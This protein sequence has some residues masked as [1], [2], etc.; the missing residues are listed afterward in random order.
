[1]SKILLTAFK[2]KY[3]SS[4]VLVDKITYDNIEKLFLTNSMNKLVDELYNQNLESFDLI[5]MFGINK[6]LKNCLQLEANALREANLITT[7][8]NIEDIQ[9]FFN[10][11]GIE[12]KINT[13]PSAYL[14]NN[15][16]YH[17][18]LKNPKGVFIHIPGL[19]KIDDLDNLIKIIKEFINYF[20]NNLR[21]N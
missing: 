7:T 20:V 16:Y 5:L 10:E 4:A 6:N 12:T 15:A 18:L 8:C 9:T 1:M 19:S 2:G 13:L 14:C 3:N 21:V 17:V 11:R